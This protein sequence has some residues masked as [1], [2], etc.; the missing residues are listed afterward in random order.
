MPDG[1][2][3]ANHNGVVD[4]GET[5]PRLLDTDGDGI[6]DGTELGYTLADIGSDTDT[7]VFQPDIDLST[8][9]D[10]LNS[11]TD[12][13][14]LS[15]GQKD[16]NYNG[17]VDPGELD[18]NHISGDVDGNGDADLADAILDLQVMAGIEPSATV[19][20]HRFSQIA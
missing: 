11:D 10:P 14:G 1:V 7:D 19:F 15:D 9:T 20:K 17:M 13:D 5:D 18:P 8:T 12:G 2:K 16:S 6:Q 3:D 4:P